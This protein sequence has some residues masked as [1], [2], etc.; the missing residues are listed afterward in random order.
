MKNLIVI[1]LTLLSL[2]VTAQSMTCEEKVTKLLIN[3]IA[4]FQSNDLIPYYSKKENKWGYFHRKTKK[5]ITEPLF[6]DAFFFNPYI[7]FY[8]SLEIKGEDGCNGKIYGSSDN[9]KTE[10]IEGSK[11]GLFG[12]SDDGN[13]NKKKTFKNFIK[14]DIS[15]FE[16]DD[17]GKLTYFNPKFYNSQNDEPA[18]REIIHFKG[19]YYGI[20]FVIENDNSFYTIINQ[21]GNP[22]PNF[23]KIEFYPNKKQTYTN[24]NDIWFFIK[25]GEDEYIFK[26]LLKGEQ[27]KETFN[28]SS[29]WQNHLQ[30][31]A[32][33]V[34]TT[35]KG[36]NGILDLTTMQWKINPSVK[37]DFLYLKY[38]S[39]APLSY[40]YEK[41]E[42]SYN[43][44]IDAPIEMI[45]ENRKKAYIYIQNSKN[46]FYDLDLNLYK[47]AK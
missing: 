32:Y 40:N 29:N 45:N 31:I 7:N 35:K 12:V 43:P 4:P 22:C 44:S 16:V 26:S 15:G 41:E 28:S 30:S 47:P 10:K 11:Y 20:V 42:H 33:A 39:L 34:F 38:S 36:E 23:E 17:F 6:S 8:Y 25:T 19:E 5:I 13:E 2:N 46:N 37:N 3:K 24:E 21:K 27:L 18:I 14:E 1:L 9:Y